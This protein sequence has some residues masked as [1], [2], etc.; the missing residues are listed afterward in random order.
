MGDTYHPLTITVVGPDSKLRV[1]AVV[2]IVQSTI[3]LPEIARLTDDS[4]QC[5]MSLPQG[6]YTIEAHDAELSAREQVSMPGTT[7]L[8]LQLR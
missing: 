5:R 1:D 4:G 3:V 2:A 6:I 7:S 8:V